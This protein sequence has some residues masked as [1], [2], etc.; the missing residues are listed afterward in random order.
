LNEVSKLLLQPDVRL[1]TIIAPGGMGKTRL[2]LAAAEHQLPHFPNGVYFV[3]L[4]PVT[5]PDFIVSTIAEAVGFQFFPG[6]EPK[7]QLLDY[8]REKQLLLVLDNFE[9]VLDGAAIVSDILAY[10]PGLKILATSRERLNLGGEVLFALSGMDFPEWETPKDALEYAAVKLF[11]QSAKRAQPGFELHG[12]DLVYLARIC[13]LVAGMPL[14]IVLAAAWVEMLSLQEIATE[15]EKSLDILET[16]RRDIPERQRSVQGVFAYAWN[17]LSEDERNV[18][19]KL[20]VF[21]GGFTRE[22][23]EKVAGATLRVL[24]GLVN[25]SLIRRNAD[26]GRYEVHELLRQYGEQQLEADSE[27][28][29]RI[30]ERHALHYVDFMEKQ[31]VPLRSRKAKAAADEIDMEIDNVR[32]A[33]GFVVKFKRTA[34]IS[35]LARVFWIFFDLRNRQKEGL[36]LLEPAVNVLTDT[37]TTYSQE[38]E[39]TL[40][41]VLS[42]QGSFYMYNGAT[43]NSEILIQKGLGILQQYSNLEDTLIALGVFFVAKMFLNKVQEVRQIALQMVSIAEFTRASGDMATAL[44]FLGVSHR[45]AH[46]YEKA[47]HVGETAL[48]YAEESGEPYMQGLCC[49]SLLGET[50]KAMGDFASSGQYFLRGMKYFEEADRIFYV[51]LMYRQLVSVF[52]ADGDFEQ[53]S[54]Y[55]QQALQFFTQNGITY[56]IAACL[57]DAASL[58]DAQG[59]SERAVE[60]L[61]AII[62]NPALVQLDLVYAQ[63]LLAD[64][65]ARL[66]PDVY[67]A[68]VERGKARD[69]DATVRELLTE[70][71]I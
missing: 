13:R 11:V 46:E 30:G 23:A 62:T 53:A 38:V 65:Q 32:S 52:A 66:T 31:S 55:L 3:A 70:G 43:K 7:Q 24:M 27:E 59:Q 67:A 16:E 58:F 61:A 29:Y 69:L 2:S 37:A 5:I 6:G 41:L 40:G 26:S 35:S 54:R 20:S 50:A 22:A 28:L 36:E 8:F 49:G 25:K 44:Y 17:R 45:M 39:L 60:L 12:D 51:A 1:V 18:F 4:A 14:A 71:N 42:V 56:Q 9:H 47:Q 21:R 68:A 15:V 64:L 57:M 19:M 48:T 34:A 63:N 33:W 10:A